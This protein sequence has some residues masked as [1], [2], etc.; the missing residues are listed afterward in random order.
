M[1]PKDETLPKDKLDRLDW[2]CRYINAPD[3]LFEEL[4]GPKDSFKFKI[5]Q[6]INGKMEKFQVIRVQYCNPY[7]T[8]VNPF[9]GGLRYHPDV[10]EELLVTLAFDM[11][12]KCALNELRFG[13]AK[14]GIAIDPAQYPNHLR[15]ITEEMTR[16]LLKRCVIGP[17]IDVMGP[18]V[19]TNSETMFWICAKVGDLNR[20]NSIPNVPA[21]VTG[22]ALED[23]GC[24]GREDATAKGGLIVLEEFLKLSSDSI[25]DL[26]KAKPRLAIQGFGNVGFN[27]TKLVPTS[28]FDI[29]AISDKNGG[30]YSAHGL[31][32]EEINKWYLEHG[33]FKGFRGAGE[34]S[35]E[36]LI[37]CNCDILVPAAIED[38]I[39]QDNADAI[40]AKIVLELA[41][42]AITDDGYRILKNRNI[43]AIPGIVA[44]SGGVVVSFMEWSRNRGTRPHKVD[45][46]RIYGEVES[47]LYMIMQ[48]L[49]R[50]TYKKSMESRLTM[51]E[52]ADVLA[53][54]TLR[55]QLKKKH[56]Y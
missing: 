3:W 8:G 56:G 45:L 7:I 42:Q 34:I 51:D 25:D 15:G 43:P 4:K 14:G 37:L 48:D 40:K 35:N 1:I 5:R 2:V 21:I 32:F 31:D 28:H 24:P 26:F 22:K 29:V 20:D 46:G 49:I 27:F 23:Y 18:D 47:E 50:K 36:Q 13:G 44:N 41:N 52:T 12:K 33:S 38:Q 53:I 39:R 16:G 10:S 17:D 6:T 9:K 19:G 55:D 54:E 11:T 30:L